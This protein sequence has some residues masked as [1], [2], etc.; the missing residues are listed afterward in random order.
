MGSVCVCVTLQM[1]PVFTVMLST[2]LPNS[3]ASGLTQQSSRRKGERRLCRNQE[4]HNFVLSE[5]IE[6][7]RGL[8]SAAF[9]TLHEGQSTANARRNCR[10]S[11]SCRALK[12]THQFNIYYLPFHGHEI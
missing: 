3:H 6:N 1:L 10:R 12:N 11:I 5:Q 4:G 7:R 2:D 8:I 9:G